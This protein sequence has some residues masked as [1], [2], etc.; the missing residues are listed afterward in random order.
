M[1]W[2]KSRKDLVKITREA[3]SQ[4]DTVVGNRLG[5]AE[6]RTGDWLITTFTGAVLFVNESLS[7]TFSAVIQDDL[8]SLTTG[9][10]AALHFT[11]QAPSFVVVFP[12]HP[13]Q[14]VSSQTK[15]KA[16]IFCNVDL[17]TPIFL[18]A[19]FLLFFCLIILVSSKKM[20]VV[21]ECSKA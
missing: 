5:E 19:R 9:G 15:R 10:F 8:V 7:L 11:F 4:N 21:L 13:W 14:P 20:S 1:S 16:I 6:M 12:R 18:R 3:F 2:P 17:T